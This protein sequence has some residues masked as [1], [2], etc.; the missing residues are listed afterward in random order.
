[1]AT[2]FTTE[3]QKLYVA[4][5]N[6]PADP[7]GLEFWN[8]AV[9]N[10]GGS[11]AAA[12]AAFAAS[13]EYKAIYSGMSNTQIIT[14]VYQNLFGHAPDP[15][16]R[17]F[18]VKALDDKIFTIDQIVAEVA[19]GAQG[20]DKTAFANKTTAAAAFTA[21]VDTDAE[22]AAY[23]GTDANNA[24]KAFI[25]KITT[26]ASLATELTPAALDAT[27]AS[28]VKAGTAFT[29][30]GGL[31]DLD[32]ANAA[33]TTY[34]KNL[35]LDD[36]ATTPATRAEIITELSDA[37]AAVVALVPDYATGTAGVKAAVLADAQV[38]ADK[39]VTDKQV[40]YN[41]AVKAAGAAAGLTS[42][43][44]AETAAAATVTAATKAEVV[45]LAAQ[46]AAEISYETLN[47]TV[48]VPVTITIASDGT[49]A[50]LLKLNTAGTL[51][52]ETGVTEAKNPG[53]TA[54]L[55][56][57]KAELTAT[58]VVTAATDA[59][60]IAQLD[61]NIR[62]S[63]GGAEVTALGT[64]GAA[65][66]AARKPAIPAAPTAAEV[67]TEILTL[68]GLL[69]AAAPAD[70]AAA[71]TKL[72]DFEAA[73]ATFNTANANPLATAVKTAQTDLDAAIKG[74]NDL[75]EAVIDLNTANTHTNTLATLDA[76]VVA[77]QG[78]FADHDF[79]APVT[80]TAFAAGTAGSDIFLVG[81]A[82]ST[83]ANFA[84]Q[85]DDVLYVG[86]DFTYNNGALNTGNNAVLEVFMIQNGAN[87]VVHL[88]TKAFGS[89]SAAE[90]EI[91][92]TLTGVNAADLV[93]T[94]GI[95]SHV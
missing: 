31:A 73:V 87:T 48:A 93:F 77:A 7:A 51:V 89:N 50:G 3:L 23:T 78:A 28:V 75:A 37:T 67:Q 61:V 20:T 60:A 38:D 33:V 22:K 11:T 26:D 72:T 19:N 88:E 41:D 42:A 79:K 56:A 45:T 18:W 16:G 62:D 27:V 34:L 81:D 55:A 30:A 83:I 46:N 76:A 39:A 32:A 21:A 65:F 12:S 10:A 25:A 85:G 15:V 17:T 47:S 53:V 92:I 14:Q 13:A 69:A 24:A 91:Q 82:V 6:R 36:D 80:L 52:L 66:D 57:V 8:T 59:H 4:Y 84:L 95:I 5:F 64:L 90:A 58:K 86:K 29:L 70:Q 49:V 44:T 74:V 2:T 63:A 1:M 94:N 35:D 71:Q 68:K 43:I 40:A 54:L 9:T